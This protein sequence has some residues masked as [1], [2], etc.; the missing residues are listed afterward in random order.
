MDAAPPSANPAPAEPSVSPASNAASGGALTF[1]DRLFLLLLVLTLV[2]VAWVGRL[3]YQEGLKT[4]T[5][6]RHGEAWLSALQH[7]HEQ[8]QTAQGEPAACR[9]QANEGSPANTWQACHEALLQTELGSLRNPFR[10]EP[11]SFIDACQPGQA[12]SVGAMVIKRVDP[13]PPGSASPVNIV[14]MS[15][16]TSLDQ[17][18]Q[19]QLKVCDRGGYAI[20]IGELTF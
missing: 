17:P 11:L 7:V 13:N 4:E 15:P 10:D 19:M 14:G 16:D 20:S 8:R 6:K 12:A 18:R 1:S 2:G 3:S 5:I 9:R